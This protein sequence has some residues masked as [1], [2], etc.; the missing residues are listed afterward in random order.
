MLSVDIHKQKFTVCEQMQ[1][2]YIHTECTVVQCVCTPDS[3]IFHID[4]SQ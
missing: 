3:H 4:F 1:Y 2:L